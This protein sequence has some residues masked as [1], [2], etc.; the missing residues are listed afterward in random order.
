MITEPKQ[1]NK[2][3]DFDELISD[4]SLNRLLMQ[5]INKFRNISALTKTGHIKDTEFCNSYSTSW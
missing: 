3:L 2:I 1:I 4:Y 5:H